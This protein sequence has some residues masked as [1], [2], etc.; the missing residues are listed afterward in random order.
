[1]YNNYIATY[2]SYIFTISPV[3]IDIKIIPLYAHM[4]FLHNDYLLFVY[5]LILPSLLHSSI[6]FNCFFYTC[7]IIKYSQKN[8]QGIKFGRLVV[9]TS[10]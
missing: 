5:F 2:M 4:V 8:W 7:N 6:L 10:Q 3:K 9:Y 1:M